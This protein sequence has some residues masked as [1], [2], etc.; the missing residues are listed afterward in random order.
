MEQDIYKQ[1][2]IREAKEQIVE[3]GMLTETTFLPDRLIDYF[4]YLVKYY[5]KGHISEHELITRFNTME[6]MINQVLRLEGYPDTI[7]PLVEEMK[8]SKPKSKA[9]KQA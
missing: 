9:R 4:R 8:Q 2:L 5:Q 1:R 6:Q 3:F 7:V